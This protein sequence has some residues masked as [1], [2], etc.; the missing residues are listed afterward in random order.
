VQVVTTPTAASVLQALREGQSTG[1]LF[2]PLFRLLAQDPAPAGF[3]DAAGVP[4]HVDVTFHSQRPSDVWVRRRWETV[5]DGST[6]TAF[7]PKGSQFELASAI[8]TAVNAGL[9][10]IADVGGGTVA[11]V[12]GAVLTAVLGPTGTTPAYSP[13]T[14]QWRSLTW[15]SS[16]IG[17]S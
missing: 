2:T 1:S 5:T 10:E 13:P 7:K 9:L 11:A 16:S 15:S 6:D 3:S 14:S 4:Y 8:V 17:S 12:G